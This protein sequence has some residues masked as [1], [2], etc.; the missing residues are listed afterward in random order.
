MNIPRFPMTG[1]PAAGEMLLGLQDSRHGLAVL[2]LKRGDAVELFDGRGGV[3]PA[4]VLGEKNGSLAVM[5]GK[6]PL[7]ALPPMPHI[8]LAASV[9]KPDRMDWLVQKAC[10]LG[11]RR[12]IPLAA[13]RGV[14]RLS[15]ERWEAKIRRW[16]KIAVESCKQCGQS[17]LPQITPIERFSDIVGRFSAYDLVILPTLAAPGKPLSDVLKGSKPGKIL[18]LIGPEGDFTPKE[19][20]QAIDAHAQAVTLGALVLRSETAALYVCSALQFYYQEIQ[21]A[22]SG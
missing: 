7:K 2:R 11:V 14:V 22:E 6:N 15:T 16:Q 18:A 19:V 10:E 3:Y 1:D 12:L 8:T 17:V 20:S 5:P 21:P 13:A 9:I 4:V